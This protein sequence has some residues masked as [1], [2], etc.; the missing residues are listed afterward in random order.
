MVGM[1]TSNKQF[2]LPV[3]SGQSPV[4]FHIFTFIQRLLKGHF[5]SSYSSP[6]LLKLFSM[7]EPLM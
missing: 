3:R 7:E 5:C 1:L 4:K 6:V 2:S